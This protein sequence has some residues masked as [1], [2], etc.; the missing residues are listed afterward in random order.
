MTNILYKPFQMF[1][2]I[3]FQKVLFKSLIKV[4]HK[5]N[6]HCKKDNWIFEVSQPKASPGDIDR[7]GGS[8]DIEHLELVNQTKFCTSSEQRSSS[9][10]RDNNL[11]K[12]KILS[13]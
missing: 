7:V 13:A 3:F 2:Q 9:P 4:L 1:V 5:E 11:N 12:E 6:V 10:I 8:R